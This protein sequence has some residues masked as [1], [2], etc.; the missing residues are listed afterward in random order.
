MLFLSDDLIG[1]PCAADLGRIRASEDGSEHR[2]GL[3]K[4][5]RKKMGNDDVGRLELMGVKD[6]VVLWLL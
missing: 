3:G 1:D 2:V 6:N 5:K 4:A